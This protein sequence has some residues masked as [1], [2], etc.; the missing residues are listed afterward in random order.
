MKYYRVE[1]DAKVRLKKMDPEDSALFKEGKEKGLKHLE[2]LTR[3]LET[4]Q[5]V[6][7][8]EHKHKVLVVLQAMDTA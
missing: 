4:L 5:E 1:P 8:G 6:L 3:K 2:E 7:Y